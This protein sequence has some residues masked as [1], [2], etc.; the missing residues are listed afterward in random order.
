MV[1]YIHVH[2]C[3]NICRNYIAKKHADSVQNYTT[4]VHVHVHFVYNVRSVY[5]LQ[6]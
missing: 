5:D 1:S 3:M 2:V 4:H 6:A